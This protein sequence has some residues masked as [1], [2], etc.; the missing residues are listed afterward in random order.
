MGNKAQA[1]RAFVSK[2]VSKAVE[3][4][5]L[6]AAHYGR[7]AEIAPDAAFERRVL[8]DAEEESLHAGALRRAAG[9]DGIELRVSWPWG[10]D[11]EGVHDAFEHCARRRDLAAC[12]FIQ[13]VFLEIV[14]IS[15]YEVL[16]KSAFEAGA[17]AVPAIVEKMILPDERM[18]LAT[19]LRAIVNL[20]PDE[21]DRANAFGR[22]ASVVLPAICVFAG[23]P[24]DAPCS[25]TCG[26]CRDRCL[27][28][29]A[30]EGEVP[31]AG[32]FRRVLDETARA[33]RRVGVSACGLLR[34]EM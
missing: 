3:S 11:L 30:C 5:E 17:R 22:A 31:W 24:L 15:L 25:R 4:E 1:T 7:L 14:S 32:G 12:L 16:A 23:P 10:G 21:A 27:K 20:A 34:A 18:H 33:A 26:A 13:D 29:D 6:A 28:L 9:R 19:G 8:E 2:A